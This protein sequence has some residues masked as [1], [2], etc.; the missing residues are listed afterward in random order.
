MEILVREMIFDF[1]RAFRER[2]RQVS[3]IRL[4]GLDNC[5]S[6]DG[7]QQTDECQHHA[8]RRQRTL[9][10]GERNRDISFCQEFHSCRRQT[11]RRR[12]ARK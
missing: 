3:R 7:D 10:F 11:R 9:G 6:S 1:V 2:V 4:P 5:R 12:A 8:D